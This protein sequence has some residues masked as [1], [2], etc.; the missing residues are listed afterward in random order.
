[1]IGDALPEI[2]RQHFGRSFGMSRDKLTGLPTGPGI[3]FIVEVLSTIGVLNRNGKSYGPEAI[4]YYLR[5]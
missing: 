4:E 5:R 3:R 2:Y 1:M